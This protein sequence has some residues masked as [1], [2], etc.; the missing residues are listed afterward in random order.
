MLF[1]TQLFDWRHWRWRFVTSELLAKHRSIFTLRE[2][3]GSL[4][5][6]RNRAIVQSPYLGSLI[7]LV[8]DDLASAERFSLHR[9]GADSPRSFNAWK[10]RY[11]H[12]DLYLGWR[13]KSVKSRADIAGAQALSAAEY[14]GWPLPTNNTLGVPSLRMVPISIDTHGR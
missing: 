4:E 2:L 12:L 9:G 5:A 6:H 7:S 14:E 13:S 10:A 11:N 1:F 8:K 3:L